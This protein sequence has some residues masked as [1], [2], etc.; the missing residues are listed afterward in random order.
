MPAVLFTV[1]S[2]FDPFI[3]S[4][5][6]SNLFILSGSMNR[7]KSVAV[8]RSDILFVSGQMGGL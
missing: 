1:R 5:R 2:L 8:W 3:V 4:P 6:L 7:I